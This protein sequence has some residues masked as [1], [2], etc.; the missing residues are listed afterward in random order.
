MERM[1][2]RE[3]GFEPESFG[4]YFKGGTGAEA[5]RELLKRVDLEA[6]ADEL[7]ETIH[8]AKGQRQ[9]APSSASRSS[10]P[11]CAAATGPSG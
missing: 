3:S 8:T 10:P 4:V 7:Q 11:S 5:V 2:G 9:A 1:F 6:E